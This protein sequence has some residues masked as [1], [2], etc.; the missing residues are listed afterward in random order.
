[1]RKLVLACLIICSFINAK[2]QCGGT[3]VAFY[4]NAIT[5]TT[6]NLLVDRPEKPK[7]FWKD[8]N[9]PEYESN[10]MVKISPY[11]YN[12]ESGKVK[13][14]DT[15]EKTIYFGF[16]ENSKQS[17]YDLVNLLPGTAYNIY[18]YTNCGNNKYE[19]PLKGFAM[20]PNSS[21]CKLKIGSLD[22][23]NA[24]IIIEA[25][26]KTIIN[27]KRVIMQYREAGVEWKEELEQSSKAFDIF[28]LTPG[29]LY[30]V[31]VRFEYSNGVVSSW[32]EELVFTAK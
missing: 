29:L 14:K 32:S 13:P 8:K 4:P 19:G 31:R 22:N 25:L 15:T 28:K 10:F 11:F 16:S 5:P 27:A 26:P 24:H 9:K 12:N 17:G 23:G 1:M 18:I 7:Q 2:S 3:V 21:P 6:I 30:A 20:T